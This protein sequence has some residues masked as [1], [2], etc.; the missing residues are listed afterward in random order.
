[1]TNLCKILEFLKV[2]LTPE[3]VH[4]E[5]ADILGEKDFFFSNRES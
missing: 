2:L 5:L 1:M 3:C 4:I